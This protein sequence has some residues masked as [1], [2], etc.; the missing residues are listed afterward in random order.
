MRIFFATDIHGSDRCWL[1]F[2]SAPRNFGCDTIII[3]G[4][5]T[6][7]FL[8]PI[9]AN[10]NGTSA[11]EYLGIKRTL[12]N[13]TEIDELKARIA[14]SGQYAMEITREEYEELQHD[15]AK[16]DVR[17]RALVLDRVAQWVAIADDRLAGRD[18][19]CFVSGANDDYFEVDDVLRTSKAIQVP[20]GAVLDVSGFEMLSVGYSNPTPWNCPRD[21]SEAELKLKIQ[22]LAKQVQR[23][24]RAVFNIHVPPFDTDIDKAPKLDA[25]LKVTIGA[26]GQPEM[27]PVGSTAVRESLLEFQPMLGLHGHIHESPGIRHLGATTIVNPGSEYAEGLLSAAVITLD[28]QKGIQE[29]RLVVG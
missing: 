6:G 24:Q 14:N 13:R 22:D 19:R 27:V 17:F 10:G 7:K 1:K 4:D 2:L 18:V 5:I 20:N 26:F 3:G 16:V 23:P 25:D 28:Q 21:I 9:I 12:R 15:P 8:V 29:I 11:T